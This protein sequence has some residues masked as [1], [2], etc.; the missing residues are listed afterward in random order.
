MYDDYN[1]VNNVTFDNLMN[2]SADDKMPD[3]AIY[4][5]EAN[6]STLKAELKVNDLRTLEYHRPDGFTRMRFYINKTESFRSYYIV[7][8]GLLSFM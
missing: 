1:Y 7:T 2:T 4:F 8:E 6:N 3:G 5:K